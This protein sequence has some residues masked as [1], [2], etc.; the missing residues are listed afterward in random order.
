MAPVRILKATAR[1]LHKI[2]GL[3]F[4]VVGFL[5]LGA[6]VRALRFSGHRSP[7][8]GREGTSHAPRSWP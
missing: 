7:S 4:L 1:R 8:P 6:A 3:T 2:S 5:A